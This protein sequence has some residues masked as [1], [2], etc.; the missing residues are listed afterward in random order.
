[1]IQAMN[2]PSLLSLL[3]FA[4]LAGG[5]V[6]CGENAVP[7][8]PSWARDI[9]PLMEAHCIRCHGAGGTLNGDPDVPPGSLHTGTAAMPVPVSCAPVPDGGAYTCAPIAGKFTT[10]AGLMPYVTLGAMQLQSYLSYPMPPPPSEA[11]DDYETNLL[12]K[13]AAHPLP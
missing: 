10:Q 12:L 3:A 9:Q 6:G 4:L 13:W 11:L 1:V 8:N 2:K 7:E 5:L